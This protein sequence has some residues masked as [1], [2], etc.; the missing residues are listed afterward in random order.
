MTAADAEW[1]DDDDYAWRRPAPMARRAAMTIYAW[2]NPGWTFLW[3]LAAAAPFILAAIVA[4]ALL[5]FTPTVDM[6]APIAEAR[7]A[8]AGQESLAAQSQPLYLLILLAADFFV[9]A[10]GR[11]HLLAKAFAAILIA[12]PMAYFASSRLPVFAAIA[13]T[14]AL[15]A[16]VASP[17]SGT[18]EFALALF[19]VNAFCFL[20]ASA[21][22]TA[23][24]ARF[25]GVVA[26][27]GLF[28]LWLLSPVFS[29]A[30]FIALSACPFLSGRCGLTRYA[31]TLAVFAIWA[32]FAELMMPGVNIARAA[33]ASGA[34]HIDA[35]LAVGEGAMGLSGVIVSTMLILFSAWV[36]GGRAHRRAWMSALG[37]GVAAYVAALLAG[38]NA[39]PVFVFMSAIAVFSVASPFYDGLFR[40]HDR[41]S[42]ALSF[43]GAAL[44]L[45]W[46]LAI[47]VH[48]AGQFSLQYQ[49][50]RAAPAHIRTELALVQPGGPTIARW[51]EEGRFSTPEAREFFALTPV[52]QSAMLL[53]AASRAKTMAADG[54][55]V[56]ILTEADTACVLAEK[57][58]CRVSGA[59]AA[60][61]AKIV[62][63][64]RLDLD[65][66]TAKAKGSAEAMLYTEFKLVEQT[67]FWDIWIRRGVAAPSGSLPSASG[68]L[69]R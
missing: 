2:Q 52:D 55:G 33:A 60:S 20:S 66:A 61:D 17:F 57:R 41:A 49:T 51:I 9:D 35:A 44:T 18:A 59:A 47:A 65:P 13:A 63:V 36:F 58:P 31:A 42:V 6:I 40:N 15:A 46:T 28:F 21:D 30:G 29:L 32:A 34:L 4:P 37:F 25:E 67:A 68:L 26:G 43:T 69:Y 22:N 3:S 10:P 56:A 39:L 50:A 62:F 8:A 14:G 12:Y 54:F 27:A 5:S 53:E 38:A 48:A 45:F 64:P 23:G 19:L 16:Y 11:I 24:R 1:D 7:A